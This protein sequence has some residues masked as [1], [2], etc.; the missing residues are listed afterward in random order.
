MFWLL[1]VLYAVAGLVLIVF[2]LR[3]LAGSAAPLPWR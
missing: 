2:A 3:V 1:F